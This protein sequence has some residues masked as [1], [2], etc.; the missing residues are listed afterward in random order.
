MLTPLSYLRALRSHLHPYLDLMGKTWGFAPD[1]KTTSEPKVRIRVYVGNERRHYHRAGKQIAGHCI[2]TFFI[3]PVTKESSKKHR[4]LADYL[5]AN[6]DSRATDYT[7]DGFEV[8]APRDL[9]EKCF[10]SHSGQPFRLLAEPFI[11]VKVD[12][13][14]EN[15]AHDGGGFYIYARSVKT[16]RKPERVARLI[17][18]EVTDHRNFCKE[19]GIGVAPIRARAQGHRW[20]PDLNID[21]PPDAV[22]E[23][24]NPRLTKQ[25][26]KRLAEV[27]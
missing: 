26:K 25:L 20:Y 6:F 13:A 18:A 8:K 15:F 7:V 9:L 19:C 5:I 21:V 3:N 23:L 17:V 16:Y 12:F 22:E 4:G 14:I 24:I 27:S 2:E 10:G 1:I 11:H